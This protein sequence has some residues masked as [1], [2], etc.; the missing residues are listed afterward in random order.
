M[1]DGSRQKGQGVLIATHSFNNR[2]IQFL[3][4]LLTEAYG[5]KTSVIK[6]GINNQF[7]LGRDCASRGGGGLIF[8]K[9]LCLN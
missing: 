7:L 2:D 8:G 1:D 3:T 6:S 4:N 5:L 9:N